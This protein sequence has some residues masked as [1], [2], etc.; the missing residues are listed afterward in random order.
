LNPFREVWAG[1]QRLRGDRA[2]GLTV[3]GISYFWFL[4]GLFQM[5]IILVAS[6]TL[7]LSELHSGLLVTALAIGIGLGSMTA[8]WLS[9]DR[10]EMGLVPCGA[11]L[12]GIC[13]I[14]SGLARTEAGL[15]PWL[16][17]VGF[18]GGLFV[19]PLNAYL[20]ER[21]GANEKGRLLAT[22]NFLNMVGVIMASGALYVMHDLLHFKAPVMLVALGVLTL[23]STVYIAWL[24]PA[25][26][27]RFIAWSVTQIFFDLR[28]N[29]AENLPK[30]GGA[31]LVSNHVSF[32]DAI[33]IGCATDRPVV[34][35]MWQVLYE[36]PWL[37]PIC[38][39]FDTI[40]LPTGAPKESLRALLHARHEIDN[41]A[42]VAIFP[43]GELSQTGHVKPFERGVE[44]LLRGDRKPPV[45]PM[46]LEGLW[47]HAL[48]KNPGHWT[49]R[50]RVTLVIGAPVAGDVTADLLY[51]RTLELGSE[52]VAL[53]LDANATLSRSFV[54]SARQHWS[55]PALADSTGK[56]L[57]FG[58]A[59]AASVIARNWTA[60]H[61]GDSQNVGL[62]LPATVGGAIANLGVALAGKTAVNL[63][64]TAGEEGIHYALKQCEIRTVISSREFLEKIKQA[65][66]PG[67]IYI[68]DGLK[69]GSKLGAWLTARLSPFAAGPAKSH[70][71]AAIVF[72]S[73][74]TGKPK[75][76]VLSHANLLANI[77]ATA[78][79]F[80]V[81][82][83]DAML[84][85]LP[86][87]HS[88]GYTYT[89]WFPMVNGFRAAYHPNPADAKAIGEMAAEHKP[90]LFL[91]TPT[92]C[93][94]YLRRCT[95]EQFASIRYL[96]VGAEKLRPALA[97]AFEK[98]LGIVLMEGYGCTE[99][100]PVVSVNCPAAQR[101][102][103][104][105][106]MMPGV[107]ARV[108]DPETLAPM[109]AGETGLLLVNGPSRMT[110]YIG[111]PDRT[112]G[113]LI[114][115]FYCTGDLARFD[116]EGYL[117]IVDR[118]SRFSKIAGEMVSHSKV[119]EAV[120]EILGEHACAVTGVPD[121]QRGERLVVLY[122]Q[123]EADPAEMWK[124]L[125][126]SPLPRLWIPKR[127]DI[128]FVETIPTLG[129][130]KLD[131]QGVKR[132]AAEFSKAVAE[133]V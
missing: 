109:P 33:L 112:A 99:M 110:G 102:G 129:T 23:I 62:L 34:F 92:F 78:Q 72:S 4:G 101:T 16:V 49:L 89:L 21:A 25:A 31:L 128:H 84:G 37:R 61:S 18:A 98:K 20:Q 86:F 38:K 55:R 94:A 88:F 105:G 127:D 113:A 114:D 74:S 26:L 42:V 2:M 90:T 15:A 120:R 14:G 43:E 17:A 69:Q 71:P 121:D 24:T 46:Y 11:A 73:G 39:L 104:A 133:A 82:P 111:D 58:H 122:T 27:V 13:S 22:N 126:A 95:R 119:E 47:G 28:V 67:T 6:E 70:D 97:E 130:G 79:V 59:L 5:T 32:A 81:G 29:G 30:T 50:H 63:N 60:R 131:L 45:I 96:L 3:T 77:R 57:T 85:A 116:A 54:A 19:V 117:Y 106:R 44:L 64:F 80:P 1:I 52:A 48:S 132:M 53:H 7:H 56:Q 68:E 35:L 76:I 12:L 100:G 40:P 10:I 75:G 87:F 91:S 108:V 65:P 107:S 66:L 41:G 8:G 93:L 83:A 125:C 51:R 9:G 124:R 123:R 118:L 115:G 103:S 36:K